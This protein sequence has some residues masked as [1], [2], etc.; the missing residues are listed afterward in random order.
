MLNSTEHGISTAHK[1][2]NT[3]TF[4]KKFLDFSLSDVVFIMFI[5]VKMPTSVDILTFVSNINF[6]LSFD[7]YEK[8]FYSL[9]ARTKHNR[10]P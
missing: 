6:T 10:H 4:K 8:K 7:E 3:D 9:G 1:H 5:N 2:L